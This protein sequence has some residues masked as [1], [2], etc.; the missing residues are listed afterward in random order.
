MQLVACGTSASTEPTPASQ[1]A[2][3]SAEPIEP[4]APAVVEEASPDEPP[5]VS[6]RALDEMD[7]S[8]LESACMAG[9]SAACDRL[10]H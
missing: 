9:S 1:V 3:P 4:E 6:D 10:G 5:P 2:M 7:Q 8:E